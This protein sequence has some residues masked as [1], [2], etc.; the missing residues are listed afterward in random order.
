MNLNPFINLINSMLSL[1]SFLLLAWMILGWLV[2]FEI[3]NQYQNIVKKLMRFGNDL[4]DPIFYQIRRVIPV[5]QG[6][7][8][9][10]IILLLLTNF[11]KEFLL[12]YLYTF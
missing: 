11:L 10:P 5:I 3:V 6:I 9:S 8:L 4:F 7:D 1:Y 2:R 12:T